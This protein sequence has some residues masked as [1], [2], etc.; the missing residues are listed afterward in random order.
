M[1]DETTEQKLARLGEL[2]EETLH[3]A[4]EETVARRREEGKLTRPRAARAAARPGLVRRARPL[5]PPPRGRV[6]DARPAAVGRR[7]RHRL[8]DDLRPQGLRLLAGL[9]DL[10]RVA[11]GG[12]RREDLQGD[13]PGGEVR[14]PGDRDQR[15]GR[16]A[17][18]G[19]R[20]LARRVRGDLLAERA[21]VGPRA[22][23]L[24]RDG[25]VCGRRR[26]LTRDHRLR[27][28]GRGL[29]V[30]VHHRPRRGEDGD[31]ARRSRS[32]SSAARPP[33]P[34]SRGSRTSPRPTR[35]HAS[36]T[37]GTCSRSCRRT[38]STGH[39]SRSR[40]TRAIAS[41]RSSTP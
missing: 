15:L 3:Q 28:H 20:R 35:K 39:R 13:G 7:G 12:L 2:R 31:R 32:R 38:T 16:R 4:K 29:V 5:R 36:R 33:T 23:A 1:A 26:L 41:R 37:P 25:A 40:P 18:P 9:H 22:A 27:L 11:V 30:H 21:V 8:R 17:D 19:G 10:R 24:A 6:R 34:R 14:L